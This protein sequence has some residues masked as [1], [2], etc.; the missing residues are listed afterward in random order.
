MLCFFTGVPEGYQ[1]MCSVQFE[2][3]TVDFYFSIMDEDPVIIENSNDY[4]CPA[5]TLP[6]II[7]GSLVGAILLLGLLA[8]IVLKICLVFLV[9]K[10][11]AHR[12]FVV[13]PW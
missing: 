1:D 7:A 4:S 9:S 10:T 6:W 13:V 11:D 3:C 8:L 5:S 12:C 2:G